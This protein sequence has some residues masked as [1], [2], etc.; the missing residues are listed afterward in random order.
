LTEYLATDLATDMEIDAATEAAT[1]TAADAAPADRDGT[2]IRIDEGQ[3]V[4]SGPR[5][6]PRDAEPL[7]KSA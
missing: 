3:E 6:R 2:T 5:R 1:D 7:R 4:L